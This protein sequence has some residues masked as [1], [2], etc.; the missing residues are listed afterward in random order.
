MV[1]THFARMS[2]ISVT[3]E[4]ASEDRGFT[5][6][7]EFVIVEFTTVSSD[8]QRRQHFPDKNAPRILPTRWEVSND[9]STWVFIL[10][11]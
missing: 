3:R 1:S 4:T 6:V 11:D 5:T 8:A 7:N 9:K 10:A 2:L